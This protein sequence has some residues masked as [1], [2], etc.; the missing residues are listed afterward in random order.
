MAV[1]FLDD[2]NPQRVPTTPNAAYTRLGTTV[3]STDT[4][5][6]QYQYIMDVYESGSSEYIARLTQTPNSYTTVNATIYFD[7]SRIF[8]GE[9]DF[10]KY[11]KVTGSIA[12]DQSVKTFE[13]KIGEQ[14]GTSPS[15]SVIVYPNQASMSLDVFPGVVN[16]VFKNDAAFTNTWYFNTSSFTTPLNNPYLTN[17]PYAFNDPIDEFPASG[18]HGL[19]NSEDYF[20]AT[21]FGDTYL[22]P[23]QVRVFPQKYVNGELVSTGVPSIIIDLTPPSGSFNT[24]G[25][26]PKNLAELDPSFSASLAA[27]DVNF[28]YTFNDFGGISYYINDKWDGVPV[29]DAG[30]IAYTG[31]TFKQ[32]SDE[33]TRFAFIN[34][35]GFWD[36]Y[37]VY[38]PIRVTTELERKTYNK[39][40]LGYD[41]RDIYSVRYLGNYTGKSQY[42]LRSKDTYSIDTQ[43]IN[44]ETANWL[45]ELLESPEVYIQQGSDFVPIVITNSTYDHNNSTAR[46]KLFN[47]TIEWVYANPRRSRL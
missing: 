46:N 5:L 4:T 15:S 24:V 7:P 27:G 25:I 36:Y 28:V 20:T 9:L 44:K 21:I 3:A 6:P 31:E 23:A 42:F 32:C 38:N 40:Q 10:D 17:A 30:I 16:P 35:Y 22:T 2:P 33:Y 19:M 1:S 37:N 13:L 11:W 45:E 29:G 14:Y 34:R 47:Y 39:P 12:P 8:Q 41:P 26:G 18:Y 43:Y